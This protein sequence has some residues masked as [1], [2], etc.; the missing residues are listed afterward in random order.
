MLLYERDR[1]LQPLTRAL[2]DLRAGAEAPVSDAAARLLQSNAPWALDLR[3]G[4]EALLDAAGDERSQRVFRA[5]CL[6]PDG[7][8]QADL[9]AEE[10]VS[11][12][13]IGQIAQ[14]AARRV[15]HALE[16]AP[17]SL[18]WAVETA[19]QRL[20][21]VTTV[22]EAASTLA[23]L[24][25]GEEPVASLILWLAG[26][27]PPVPR[28]P[29]WL[30]VDPREA[31]RVTAV[32]LAADGGV[33]RLADVS[34][35][36]TGFGIRSGQL[37]AWL[38]A[39]HAAVVHELVVMVE[40]QLADV[41]ERLLDAHGMPRSPADLTAELAAGGR[42]VEAGSLAGALRGRRFA[43]G[44]D[45]TVGLAAWGRPG[46]ERSSVEASPR[47]G[48]SLRRG[49]AGRDQRA[50][51]DRPAP[52]AERLWLWARIDADALKG[53]EADVP[54]GLVEGLGM[55]RP[56]RRTFTSRWGPVTLAH[57]GTRPTRGS[58]RAV[59]LAAGACVDDSLL[60]GF[61]PGGDVEVELRSGPEAEAPGATLYGGTL[62]DPQ[63]V[64]GGRR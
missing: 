22:D 1:P 48:G 49:P 30:A 41:A 60:L 27:Y 34:G 23:A 44:G 35:E 29:G 11:A 43:P 46:P 20:G 37:V 9:A 63:S 58:L 57:D 38:S 33:R 39:N 36:L 56:A 2:L 14:S 62:F 5:W 16:E 19:K 53:A 6:R 59:A 25:G 21:R 10:G 55:R 24:G 64:T 32:C 50:G 18:R 28:R 54:L 4:A 45:G 13:R 51:K 42:V 3:T 15:R 61:S 17:A 31:L 26:P 47:A 7:R 40:G 52:S 12:Q 8:S